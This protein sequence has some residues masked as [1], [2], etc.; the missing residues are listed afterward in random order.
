MYHAATPL[1]QSTE[2]TR[3]TALLYDQDRTKVTYLLTG[4]K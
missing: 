2:K 4:L 1:V 3:S